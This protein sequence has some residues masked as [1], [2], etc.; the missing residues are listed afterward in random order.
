MSF[1]SFDGWLARSILLLRCDQFRLNGA[2]VASIAADLALVAVKGVNDVSHHDQHLARGLLGFLVIFLPL[3]GHVAVR[4]LHSERVAE[5]IHNQWK[6]AG[7]NT[8]QALDIVKDLLRR[9]VHIRWLHVNEFLGQLRCIRWRL[10]LLW[11]AT[12]ASPAAHFV[13]SRK[14]FLIDEADHAKH[15]ARRLLRRLVVLLPLILRVAVEAGD[16][17]RAADRLH[18]RHEPFS[19]LA[20][21]NVHVFED[22]FC[23]YR[24]MKTELLSV[25]CC[26]RRCR[27][28]GCA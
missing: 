27:R 1:L 13:F 5:E 4:A 20:F 17:K 2:F 6:S 15:F 28:T 7:G 9:F 21:E 19:R 11:V 24:T 25:L 16:A 10:T 8:F 26:R 23:R 3:I 22:S 12:M 14:I 18:S